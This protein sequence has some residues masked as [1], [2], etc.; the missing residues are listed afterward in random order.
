M[1]WYM[2]NV[3]KAGVND[4]VAEASEKQKDELKKG[5]KMPLISHSQL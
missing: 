1:A 5:G 4:D 2:A 3:A